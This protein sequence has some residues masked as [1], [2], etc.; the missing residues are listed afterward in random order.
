MPG[1]AGR[2]EDRVDARFCGEL[3][4]ERVLAAAAADD[5]DFHRSS[6]L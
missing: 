5:E 3:P 1:V 4:G 6:G 2:A